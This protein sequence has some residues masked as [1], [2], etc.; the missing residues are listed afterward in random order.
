MQRISCTDLGLT[1]RDLES[2]LVSSGYWASDDLRARNA[3]TL[4]PGA[5]GLSPHAIS[6]LDTL[7]RETY[8]A[9]AHVNQRLMALTSARS[10][11]NADAAFVKM[12][13]RAA[14]DLLNPGET[15]DVP[16]VIKLDLVIDTERAFKIVEVDAYNPRGYGYLALLDALVPQTKRVGTGIG[17]LARI[18][19][20]SSGSTPWTIL[21]SEHER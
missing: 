16:P 13:R 6:S 4:S 17:G 15:G 10:L 5:L 11:S 20:E 2:H 1:V 14:R 21:V 7:A 12:A 8:S 9:L 18:M 3:C 19:K